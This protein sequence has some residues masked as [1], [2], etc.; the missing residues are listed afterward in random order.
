MMEK[1]V[2][3]AALEWTETTRQAYQAVAS[4]VVAAQEHNVQF[5]QTVFENGVAQLR[6]QEETARG[7]FQTMAEQTEKQRTAFQKLA[8]ESVNAYLDLL[9]APIAFYQKGL[10][11]TRQAA[12]KAR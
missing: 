1:G 9:A 11:V 8:Q 12:H 10:D 7:L 5:A 4:G 3:Q 6:A 2:N